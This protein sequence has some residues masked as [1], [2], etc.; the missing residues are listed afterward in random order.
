MPIEA[1]ISAATLALAK[2]SA[3]D[4][5]GALGIALP[6]WN[7]LEDVAGAEPAL[8]TLGRALTSASFGLGRLDSVAQYADRSIL[9]AEA[10]NDHEALSTPSGSPDF[11]TTPSALQS[12]PPRYYRGSADIARKFGLDNALSG[13]LSNQVAVAF[14]HDLD[15]ALTLGQEA[16][17]A[18]RR[19]GVRPIIDLATG[20]YLLSLWTAGRLAEAQE[21]HRSAAESMVDPGSRFMLTSVGRWLADAI[22]S[23]PP[24][25][26][27]GRVDP[28]TT[29]DAYA[30]AWSGHLRIIDALER[31]DPRRGLC[32]RRDDPSRDLARWASRT[33][34]STSGPR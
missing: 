30:L 8:L 13:A 14:G 27:A 24:E 32:D 18:A 4:N 33:S 21:V 23:V 16:V 28:G 17:E 20:N 22:G 26:A 5:K 25:P 3:G 29:D 7:A 34:S 12:L 31:G 15:A 19:S 9:I 6:R 11:V 2:T 10:L 1:G